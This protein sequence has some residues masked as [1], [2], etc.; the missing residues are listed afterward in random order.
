MPSYFGPGPATARQMS[1]KD[2]DQSIS[3]QFFA[4][5]AQ[6]DCLCAFKLRLGTSK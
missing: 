1:V 5:L 2:S 3:H 6:P 4:F